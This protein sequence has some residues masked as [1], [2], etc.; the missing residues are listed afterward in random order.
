MIIYS[1]LPWVSDTEYD[2]SVNLNS[3]FHVVT[4]ILNLSCLNHLFIFLHVY[5]MLKFDKAAYLA[6]LFKSI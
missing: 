5:Y 4:D 6:L 3:S 2:L 1:K